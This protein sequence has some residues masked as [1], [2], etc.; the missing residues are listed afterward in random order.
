MDTVI[1]LGKAGCAIADSFGEYS[2]YKAYKIDIGLSPS[3]NTFSLKEGQNIEDYEKN[4]PDA[5]KFFEGVSGDILFVVGGGGKSSLA[6][7]SLLESLRHCNISV[8]YI[9]PEEDFLAAEGKLINNLVF[10][11]LQEYARSGIFDRLY[12]VDNVLVEKAIPPTSLK[13]HYINLN[14]AI[15]S[16]LHMINVFN[17][18]PS[19]TDTFSS[20]PI[21]TRISTIGFVE[22]KKNV[23]KMFFSLDNVSDRV[24]YYACNKMRLE[25][26]N[27]LFGEIKNSLKRKMEADVRVSYGIFETDYDEDYI[28]CVAH[29]SAIQGQTKT[30]GGSEDL[31]T[32]P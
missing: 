7:L 2:Q 19:V 9:K 24:Y 8:L 23:D 30:I 1:G 29:T 15:V 25:T 27:N 5:S 17:H 6:S 10:N 3:A 26:E 12:L 22:P 4:C 14:E 20:L 31:P 13:N 28:Y 32:S 16:S 11:V 21:G 18:I